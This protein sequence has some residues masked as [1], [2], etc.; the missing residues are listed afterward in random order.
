MKSH[1]DI[2]KKCDECNI[3]LK[4]KG[5]LEIY[6]HHLFYAKERNK[7]NELN[8]CDY[9]NIKVLDEKNLFAYSERNFGKKFFKE[10]EKKHMSFE[11][12]KD[13]PYYIEHWMIQLNQK[14]KI[15]V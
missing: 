12:N 2:C 6:E 4:D 11:I 5:V 14:T 10:I 3:F 13:C 7:Y 15:K 8:F 9:T 1:I